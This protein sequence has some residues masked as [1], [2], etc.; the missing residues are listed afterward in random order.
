MSHIT[1][2]FLGYK[3]DIENIE[4]N[5]KVLAQV[6]TSLSRSVKTEFITS[7]DQ[8]LQV[9]TIEVNSCRNIPRHRHQQTKRIS[10]GTSEVL[11]VI[12]GEVTAKIFSDSSAD[13]VAT[14]VLCEGMVIV[15]HSGGHSFESSIESILLEVKNGPY[16]EN[17]DKVYF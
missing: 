10:F 14:R 4:E 2:E 13:L 8:K 7:P 11:M 1:Q 12:K 15:L 5:G 3:L 6:L 17:L 16:N 9:G